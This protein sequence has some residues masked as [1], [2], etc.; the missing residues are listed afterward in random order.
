MVL[1]ISLIILAYLCGSIPVGVLLARSAGV[2]LRKVGS[3]NIGATNVYRALGRGAGAVTLLGDTLKG[4][5][6]VL[7]ARYLSVEELWLVAV[8][9]AAFLGHLYPV[10]LKFSGGKGVATGFGVYLGLAPLVALGG[11][12]IWL[13][14]FALGRYASLSALVASLGIASLIW[15][16]Y[17]A[18]RYLIGFSL[19]II[20]F[21][22]WHHRENIRNLWEGKEGR[23]KKEG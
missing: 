17:P 21:V 4:L 7:L 1:N 9:L 23:F 18:D 20:L 22:Y 15:Y 13:V 11:L 8:A 19:L 12:L 14:V 5:G 2:N 3:G 16:R 6:P 10:F